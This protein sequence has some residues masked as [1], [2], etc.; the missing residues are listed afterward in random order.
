M[1]ILINKKI[2]KKTLSKRINRQLF[3]NFFTIEEFKNL[4]D[5]EAYKVIKYISKIES[6][7]LKRK[8]IKEIVQ[9]IRT[10]FKNNELVNATS[11][12]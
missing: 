12:L 10:D 11:N 6:I 8:E 5:R 2:D 1:K 9:F 4:T 3:G 7:K